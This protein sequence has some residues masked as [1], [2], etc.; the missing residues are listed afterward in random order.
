MVPCGYEHVL[1]QTLYEQRFVLL[2]VQVNL[3]I[4]CITFCEYHVDHGHLTEQCLALCQEI[5]NFIKNG[6]L[7]SLLARERNQGRN[8]QGPLLLEGNRDAPED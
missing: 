5:E 1:E 4:N 8:P 3:Y 7:V 6:R 2:R